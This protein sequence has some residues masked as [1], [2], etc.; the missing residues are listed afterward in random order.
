MTTPPELD[1]GKRDAA[2]RRRLAVLGPLERDLLLDDARQL[3][4][5]RAGVNR[6]PQPLVDATLLELLEARKAAM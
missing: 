2:L 5:V 3:A 4:A 1:T 6:A